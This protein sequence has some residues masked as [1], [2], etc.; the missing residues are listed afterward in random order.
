MSTFPG[1]KYAPPGV[2]TQ[3]FFDNPLAG[4]LAALKI[5]V[6]IGTGN[7]IL[8]NQ[9]L[10]VSRGSSAVSDQDVPDEDMAGRAVVEVLPTGQVVLGDFDGVLNRVQVR[11][12]PIVRGD[13]TGITTNDRNAVEVTINQK[14]AV[15]LSVDGVNGIITLADEPQPGDVVRVSYAFNRTDTFTTDVLSDQVTSDSAIVRGEIG[16]ASGETFDIITGSNDELIVTVDRESPFTITLPSGSYS[17]AQIAAVINGQPTGTLVASTFENNHGETAVLLSA[18]IDIRIGAG[19]ANA[20]FGFTSGF[21]TNRNRTFYTWQGPI[22]DGSNGGVTTTTVSHVVVRVDGTPVTAS[23][24]DGAN[25][26][27]VLPYAPAAGSVVAVSYYYNTWQDTFDYLAHI[28][29]T[30]ILRCGITPQRSDF[31][32]D[33]DFVLKDDKILW[34]SAALVSDGQTTAGAIAFGDSQASATLVDQKTYLSLCSSVVDASVTPP[35]QNRRVFQL[36]FLATT[37][38]GRNTPLSAEE[39]KLVANG[40]IDL[41]TNRPDLITAYWGFSLQDALQRGPVTVLSVDS[42]NARITLK[43]PVEVG[44]SV[45]ATFYYNILTDDTFTLAVKVPG[46]ASVGTYTVTDSDGNSY[47]DAKFQT[48]SAGLTGITVQFPSGSELLP[49]VRVET[50]SA[51][52][53]AGP[54]EEIVT[55][56]FATSEA[57]PAFL[58]VP[59]ADPY[60]P[61][62]NASDQARLLIDGVDLA[63]GAGGISLD[64]PTG[65]GVG[66]FASLVG[67]EVVYDASSGNTT[68]EIDANNNEVSLTVDGVLLSAT[69]A[70]GA[71]QD[72]SDY[73]TALNTASVAVG[74]EPEYAAATKFTSPLT[75]TAGEYDQ[76]VL[77]YTGD[78]GGASG[79]QTITLT[80][81]TFNSVNALVT[82]I[83]TQLATINAGGG[84]LGTVNCA[85]NSEG[86]LV[87]DLT[88]AGGDAAG[89]LEF[90][91]GVAAQDFAIIAGIDTDAA[92]GGSQTKLYSGPIARRFTV[93][94]GALNHDRLILRNRLL[95]GAGSMAPFHQSAQ[96]HVTI[97]GSSAAIETGVAV[98]TRALGGTSATVQPATLLGVTGFAD[99]QATGFADTRDSQPV[100]IFYDGT[101]VEAANNVFKFTMDGTP[102]TVVF[103][104]SGAGTAAA[105][106]PATVAGT[107]IND[108]AAAM[109]TA[110]FGANAAAVLAAGLIYQEGAGIRLVSSQTDQFSSL[111]IGTGNANAS[112]GFQNNASAL[113]A[114]VD[115]RT[116]A[117]ALMGH[118]AA[119]LSAYLLTFS[120]PTA[121]YFAAEA[122][123]GYLTDDL[124]AEYLWLQSQSAGIGSSVI[125]STASADD[126]LLPGTNILALAGDGAVGEDG[127]SGFYVTSS[128]P[129]DGS[130][131]ANTSVF[132]SGSGQDGT[133]GQ[134]YRDA[135]TGVT[136]TILERSGGFG[137]PDGENFTMKVSRTFTTDSNIPT[138]ALPGVELL[139]TNTTGTAVGDTALVETFRKDGSEPAVGDIY[140][141]TYAFTKQ[142]FS[143][144]LFTKLAAIESNYGER[145]PDNPVSLASY[146]MFINGAVSIAIKQ[147]IKDSGQDFASIPTYLSALD[148]LSRPLVGGLNSDVL[149]PLTGASVDFFKLLAKHCDLQSSRRYRQERTAMVGLTPSVSPIQAGLIP[150]QIANERV[151]M[152]YPDVAL[153]SLTDALGQVSQFTVEG[154]YMA[155]ALAGSVVAPNVDVATP[156]TN[157]PIFGF[158]RL[159]R[160]LSLVEQN[161]VAVTGITVLA[162]RSPNL[163]V[164]QGLTTDTTNVLSK[165]PTIRLIADEVQIRARQVLNRFVGAKFLP[166]ILSDIEGSLSAMLADLVRQQIIVAFQGVEASLTDDPTTAEVVAYYSPVFPL[167]Y[168]PI[169]FNLR[170]SL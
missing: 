151:R 49:D 67:E 112:L 92:T 5:P 135:V 156:W 66:F 103:T 79:N 125:W 94:A 3:T 73:V 165:T 90:I 8:F 47:Y 23:S 105:L 20:V 33:V 51:S 145:S 123:S 64:D 14:P 18:D 55:V 87:F 91:D 132:N 149:V 127:I 144:Q 86:Q 81:G 76:L 32:Q 121:T 169:T 116:L 68:Y 98:G 34:G 56:T 142:D 167:L 44:A 65:S 53:F 93:G 161:Q 46:S 126:I 80:P 120:A 160:I 36:P 122:M 168:I 24:V 111:D 85:A 59:G 84:L 95:P 110:G 57:R 137:Y 104:A 147:V 109:A 43:D 19:S 16:L 162:E 69:A 72:L 50:N 102:V 15:A 108:I 129:S 13:G 17:A 61:I 153:L 37:G 77:H 52:T 41:P 12:F 83:N 136:F 113:R 124:G 99:G 58:S 97:Q 22:V 35:V 71:T 6:I 140:Y 148:D 146:L 11:N 54:V 89:F 141:V 155:A 38:N 74:N 138:R 100:V 31:I 107:V 154:F 63:S 101:G 78:I 131:T 114:P 45:W 62:A 30:E 7:E 27:V 60:Y 82:E 152:V 75:I 39:F 170:T 163:Y 139:V 133:V 10:E 4:A 1:R 96:A 70:T 158:D 166:G 21:F 42:E 130:G 29:V 2:Y 106:G 88:L 164:R 119:T 134:T 48:K 118:H 157:R 25:R 128:D 159:G 40:R 150:G 28:N 115:V 26:A 9:D 117:S 143:T